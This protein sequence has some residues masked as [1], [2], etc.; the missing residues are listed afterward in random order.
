MPA[1]TDMP[2]PET[3]VTQADFSRALRALRERAGLTIR[4]IAKASGMPSSTVGDYFSGRHLPIGPGLL[5]PV[6][7]ACGDA[8]AGRAAAWKAALARVRRPPGRRPGTP[9]RGLARFEREHARWFSGREDIT[10]LLAAMAAEP[11]GLPL[12]L[13]GPSGAGKSSLLRAGLLPRL[14]GAGAP[15]AAGPVPA[16]GGQVLV[17]EPTPDPAADF[18]ARL[19]PLAGGEGRVT[20]I[21]DQFEAVFTQC[22]DEE[23]QREFIR[24]VCDLARGTLVILALRAGFYDHAIRHPGLA[25]ALQQR[26]VVLGPMSPGQLRRA[27]TRPGGAAPGARNRPRCHGGVTFRGPAV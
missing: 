11:S 12:M 3:I 18:R 9:Y 13:V 8:D 14:P 20:V 10:E 27:I 5:L 6:L 16:G 1:D 24:I 26:Q 25:A 4:E 7:R 19:A 23:K 17:F 21:V 2:D 15:A 22:E